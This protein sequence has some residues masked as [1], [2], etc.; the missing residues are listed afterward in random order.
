M[1]DSMG[2][3]AVLY[4]SALSTEALK[5]KIAANIANVSLNL[6]SQP[7]DSTSICHVGQLQFHDANAAAR[8]IGN[9]SALSNDYFDSLMPHG[10]LL[11][12][13]H[14]C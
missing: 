14:T 6:S 2:T 11:K 3:Q 4:D 7:K 12:G 13:K 9:L 1:I 8:Y 5:I 10:S